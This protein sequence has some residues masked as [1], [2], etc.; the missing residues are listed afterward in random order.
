MKYTLFILNLLLIGHIA[1][2]QSSNETPTSSYK[3]T[4]NGKEYVVNSGETLELKGTFTDPT[5]AVESTNYK[6]FKNGIIEFDY[7]KQF[8]YQFEEDLGYKNWTL[9]G[10]DFTIMIFEVIGEASTMEFVGEIVQ[11]FGE[12]N[13]KVSD[14]EILLGSKKLSGKNIA[15][16]LLGQSIS[17]DFVRVPSGPNRSVFI[18][19][20]DMLTDDKRPSPEG[21][22]S[23]SLIS[24]TI[25]Y[26]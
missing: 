20:Q 11:Q 18:A 4:I 7:E 17:V 23:I 13:C 9:D 16:S 2:A 22:R 8:G 1:V 25:E 12:E 3:I 15:V 21:K 19:F 26:K 10:N 24:E 14:T 6:H 5:I